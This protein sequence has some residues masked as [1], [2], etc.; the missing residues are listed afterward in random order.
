M[1]IFVTASLSL[2]ITGCTLSPANFDVPYS[3]SGV[4]LANS[5]VQRIRCELAE[6]VRDDLEVPYLRRA[7]LI[8]F[9]YHVAM[10]LSL[11]ANDTASVAPSLTFPISGVAF[12][13]TPSAKLSRQD[14]IN[15][16][17]KYSMVD[18]YWDWKARPEEYACPDPNTNLAGNLGIREK[19]SSALN[20]TDLAFVTEAKPT[21]G[22]FS[23]IINFTA[24]KSI[25]QA[26]PTWTLAN[27]TGPG[28]FLAASEV[29]T[30][31]LAFG[32][33]AG[34]GIKIV[35]AKRPFQERVS[36]SRQAD[37][38]L[39]RALTNDLGTQLNAIRSNQR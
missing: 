14:Q 37:D 5:V 30:D 26:G 33:A 20:L 24:T 12:N 7:T 35:T 11:D 31:K 15:Y 36:T 9:D 10:L 22:Q 38:A 1:R 23:G 19:V 2:L 16:S 28:A 21:D 25:N 13:I 34:K 32:F 6:L 27:F 17:L 18:L 8:E 29:N 39:S 3:K 4:P